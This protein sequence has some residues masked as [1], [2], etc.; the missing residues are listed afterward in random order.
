MSES[1]KTPIVVEF[2]REKPTVAGDYLCIR[3]GNAH[4]EFARIR[5]F[6]GVLVYLAYGNKSIPLDKIEDDAVFSQRLGLMFS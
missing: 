4:P 6:F 3:E 2:T 1:G 5:S